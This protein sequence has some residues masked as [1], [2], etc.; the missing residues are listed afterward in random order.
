MYQLPSKLLSEFL[1]TY[2]LVLTVGLNVLS[3]SQAA[4]FSIAASLMCMIYALGTVSG[5]H[6][7]PAVTAAIVCS[8]RGCISPAEAGAYVAVQIVG[9]V[10][11]A[12]TY[13][14]MHS[15]K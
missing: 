7:N 12:F 13:V 2:M 4:V 6:F 11:A 8:G 3:N 14:A 5:A 1:G 9:G 15:G 10:C